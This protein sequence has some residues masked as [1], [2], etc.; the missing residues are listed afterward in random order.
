MKQDRTKFRIIELPPFDAVSSGVDKDF[1]FSEKGILGKFGRYFSDIKPTDRDRFMP[2]DFLFFDKTQN[3][4]VWWWALAPGMDDGSYEHV[5]FDGG[6][7]LTYTFVDQDN[8]TNNRLY[9]EALEFIEESEIFELDERENHYSMG[10]IITPEKII[11]KQ[12][13]SMMETFIP[14]KLKDVNVND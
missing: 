5:H 1:D 11:E 10:H 7:F 13:F 12:G 8:E 3:G 6:Y 2:R 14:I 4:L 9:Q